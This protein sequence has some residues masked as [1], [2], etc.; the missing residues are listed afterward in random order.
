MVIDHNHP[1]YIQRRK[2]AGRDKYNGAFYYSEEIVR[3]I[4]PNVETSRNWITVNIPGVASSDSIVFIHNNAKPSNYDWLRR[5]KNLILV[6]GIPETVP[7][8]EHLGTAIYLPLS[9][10]TEYVRRFRAKEKRKDAAFVGRKMKLKYGSV[11]DG[12]DI[13]SGM[14]REDLL[15]TMAEYRFVYAVGRTA[16]EAR[17]LGCKLRAYDERYPDVR[18]WRVI[19]NLEAAAR[20]QRYLDKIDGRT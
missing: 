19:D 9:I 17:C 11:P 8:V 13:I 4:I 2:A 1:N 16:I 14:E 7:K 15:R 20:L 18:R 12:V 5:Y 10:D 6:C 3:N